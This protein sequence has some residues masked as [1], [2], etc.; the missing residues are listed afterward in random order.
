MTVVWPRVT[1]HVPKSCD[2]GAMVPCNLDPPRKGG[3]TALGQLYHMRLQVTY[4]A[5]EASKRHESVLCPMKSAA[6]RLNCSCSH[7]PDCSED[8]SQVEEA[9]TRELFRPQALQV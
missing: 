5:A 2:W 7:G 3:L 6:W 4:R 8:P 9:M 1:D